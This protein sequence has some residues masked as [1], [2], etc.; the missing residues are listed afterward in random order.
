[1]IPEIGHFLLWLALGVSI[2][3]GTYPLAGAARGNRAWMVLV[4]PCAYLLLALVLLAYV[5]LAA[6]F[7]LND[8]SVLN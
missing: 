3:M 5:C 1:M 6:S 4:R 8:F 7:V 2:V